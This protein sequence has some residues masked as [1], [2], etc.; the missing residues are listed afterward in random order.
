VLTEL[1]TQLSLELVF[2]LHI[3]GSSNWDVECHRLG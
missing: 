3:A 2:S 1:V